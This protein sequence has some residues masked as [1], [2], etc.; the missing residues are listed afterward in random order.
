MPKNSARKKAQQADQVDRHILYEESVQDPETELEFVS[1]TFQALVGRPLKKIRED[2]CG[3]GNTACH[4]VGMDE[5]HRAIGVDLD[6]DVLDW[7]R[8]HHVA[9]LKAGARDRVELI[10]SNVLEVET[11]P[12]DAILAMNFSYYL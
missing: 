2:F 11:G 10:E 8:R 4:W 9:A 12:V 5:S 7:G 3:T 6:P 1:D